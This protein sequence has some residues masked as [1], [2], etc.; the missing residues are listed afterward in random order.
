MNDAN[1]TMVMLIMHGA[2]SIFLVMGGL[3]ALKLG[4]KLILKGKG[5]DKTKTTVEAFRIKVTVGTIGST[6]MLT[7]AAWGWAAVAVLPNYDY[8]Y[9]DKNKNLSIKIARVETQLQEISQQ[10]NEKTAKLAA[11]EEHLRVLRSQARLLLN[12]EE[13]LAQIEGSDMR[14]I[15]MLKTEI[16]S[17]RNIVQTIE[18]KTAHT[19]KYVGNENRE[20][21]VWLPA[22]YKHPIPREGDNKPE[23][24]DK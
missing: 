14:K 20:G 13:K 22:Y 10:M 15:A 6:V 23:Q 11:T 2:V 9:K 19:L 1:N 12:L 17:F 21:M 4:L 18:K 8:E 5:K 3:Y 16:A 24:P 7:A